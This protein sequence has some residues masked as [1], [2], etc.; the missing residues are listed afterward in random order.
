M[1]SVIDRPES[2]TGHAQPGPTIPKTMKAV[3]CYAPNDYRLEEVAVPT[4]GPNEILTKVELCGIC[5]GDVKTFRGAPS[6]WG[7]AE[8]PRPI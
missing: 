6:F 3:V 4:P 5:M 8:Q 1:S 7:D 2:A